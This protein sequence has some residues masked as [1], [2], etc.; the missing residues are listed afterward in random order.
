[1]TTLAIETT[2]REMLYQIEGTGGVFNAEYTDAESSIKYRE[3][4]GLD[5]PT[6]CDTCDE[7][8]W[9]GVVLL[10][11]GDFWCDECFEAEFEVSADFVDDPF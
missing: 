8:T 1:M 7:Q 6:T 9:S 2:T 10:D 3:I 5:T 11:G 4:W